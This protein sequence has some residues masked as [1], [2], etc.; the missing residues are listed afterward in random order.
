MFLPPPP[1]RSLTQLSTLD[2]AYVDLPAGGLT[3]LSGMTQLVKCVLYGR[4]SKVE[5]M[6]SGVGEFRVCVRRGVG[7]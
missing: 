1:L 7:G 5:A 4:L 2:L 6:V 3:A